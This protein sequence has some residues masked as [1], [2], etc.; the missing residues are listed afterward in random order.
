MH[1]L[2]MAITQRVKTNA[3]VR[4]ERTLRAASLRG[5]VEGLED[6]VLMAADNW[7]PLTGG[8]WEQGTNWSLGHAPAAGDDAVI[9][10]TDSN[11]N[12][13]GSGTVTFNDPTDAANSIT[14][15]PTY[16]LQFNAATFALGAGK[17]VLNGTG[18]D[19]T[20]V[21]G[22]TVSVAPNASFNLIGDTITDR[23]T[24]SFGAGDSVGLESSTGTA[25]IT[26]A[27]GG[28]LAA[29]TAVG[30]TAPAA[31][32]VTFHTIP[33]PNVTPTP[34]TY[35]TINSGGHLLGS[36]NVFGDTNTMLSDGSVLNNGDL[37]GNDFSGTDLI[38][39]VID[40]P[41]VTNNTKFTKVDLL[42]GTLSTG[43]TISLT[44]MGTVQKLGG[45][46][47][48]GSYTINPGATLNLDPALGLYNLSN[49]LTV[50]GALNFG[51]GDSVELFNATYVINGQMTTSNTSFFNDPGVNPPPPPVER[52]HL[53]DGKLGRAPDR[54]G[55]QLRVQLCDA[56]QWGNPE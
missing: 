1:R 28:V 10:P 2:Q 34:P 53:L 51:S 42:G 15:S 49:T 7:L 55:K 18:A 17:T 30:T 19:V 50:D 40:V 23:G 25:T 26:V 13:I 35:I 4:D 38:L 33:V 41:L 45:Y 31:T 52:P 21:S 43:N 6:R 8:I 54:F 20:I 12:P 48:I 32:G 5:A 14:L 37:V 47:F 16:S 22:A 11:G 29:N 46:R 9:F 44:A 56:Q 39:P 3:R 27:N 24:L 36:N